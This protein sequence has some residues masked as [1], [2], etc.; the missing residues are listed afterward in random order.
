[1]VGAKTRQVLCA[2]DVRGTICNEPLPCFHIF[3]IATTAMVAHHI[4]VLSLLLLL[5]RLSDVMPQKAVVTQDS[6]T[7][8]IQSKYGI[9]LQLCL[10]L[11][12]E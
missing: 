3:C 2:A 7:P 1:M 5:E 9:L 4:A 12:Y 8:G 10:L 11:I 6:S